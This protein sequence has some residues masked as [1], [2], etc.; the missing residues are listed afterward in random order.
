M[1]IMIIIKLSNIIV[2][3]LLFLLPNILEVIPTEIEGSMINKDETCDIKGKVSIIDI[4][5]YIL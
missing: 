2:Q 3:A 1:S 4:L 5:I